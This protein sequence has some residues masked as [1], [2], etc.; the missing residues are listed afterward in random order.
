[1]RIAILNWSLRRVGGVETYLEQLL[2]LLMD[3]GHDAA[4]LH[5]TD[6]PSHRDRLAVP[7]GVP[8]WNVSVM[9]ADQALAAMRRW[10]PHI[11][12]THIL[13][14]TDLEAGALAIGVPS[15]YFAHA[16]HGTCI[17]G[18]KAHSFPAPIPCNRRFG[19][20]CLAY[21]F[22]RRCGGL[23]A[24]TMVSAYRTQLRRL[25]LIRRHNAVVTASD[26]MRKE[27][28]RHG[29]EPHRLI[30]LPYGHPRRGT[31]ELPE[32]PARSP[33]WR[34]LFLGRM[35]A[36]KG[37]DALLAAI[38]LLAEP[39]R[40]DLRVIVAGDGPARGGWERVGRAVQ[41]RYPD[42]KVEFTGWLE[43]GA[44]DAAMASAHLL[45]VPSLWPE[46]FGR[47]G[48]EAGL[49][50]TPAVAF[51][52][53]GIS[54]WLRDG[55]NGHFAPADPPSA[56]GLAAA[57]THSLQDGAHYAALRAGAFEAATR[58]SAEDH[59]TRL[60]AV[61]DEVARTGSPG[62]TH[63]PQRPKVICDEAADAR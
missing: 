3:K 58:R 16:Y 33:G 34:L 9:G 44:R 1:M 52:V 12:Y 35:D 20:A 5:E 7:G 19:T 22:P 11:L 17:S 37:G 14:D 46:P 30:T 28:L 53:G 41:A 42:V 31:Y 38:P 29:V 40:R 23:S 27:Y 24:L 62:S 26:H 25:E 39:L 18:R 2:P 51:D 55:Y 32:P 15:V 61:L 6:V 50:G 47:V 49:W 21:Y 10:Q 59:A 63:D 43:S 48:L 56:A 8:C 36:L 4:F 54:E 57:I 45:V 60:A 13:S